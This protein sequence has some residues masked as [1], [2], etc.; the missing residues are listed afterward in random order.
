MSKPLDVRGEICPYPMMKAVEAIKKLAP[1]ETTLEVLT[2]H[3]PALT[4]IPWEAAKLGWEADI[5]EV[6]SPEW[7]ITLRKT[8]ASHDP[9]AVMARLQEQLAGVSE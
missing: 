1:E 2:D 5:E 6:G 7:L 3:A 8:G 9:Q 4:T